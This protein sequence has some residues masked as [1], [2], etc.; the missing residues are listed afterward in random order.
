MTR[1]PPRRRAGRRVAR[2]AAILELQRRWP[3]LEI[4]LIDQPGFLFIRLRAVSGEWAVVEIGEGDVPGIVA[5]LEHTA[6]AARDALREY[7]DEHGNEIRSR[8]GN[9]M[10]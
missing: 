9:G 4:C 3:E 2:Q 8:S 10:T 1:W 5:L 7:F 6:T